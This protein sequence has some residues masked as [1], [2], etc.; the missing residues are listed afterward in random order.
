MFLITQWEKSEVIATAVVLQMNTVTTCA[1]QDDRRGNGERGGE[2]EGEEERGRGRERE[3]R[4]REREIK[5]KRERKQARE[6]KRERGRR[7]K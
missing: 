1:W 5:S 7:E 3:E 4:K 6:Q 2:R